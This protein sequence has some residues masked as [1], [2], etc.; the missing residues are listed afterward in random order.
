MIV[1]IAMTLAGGAGALARYLVSRV[2]TAPFGT[3]IV[4]VTGAFALGLL[5]GNFVLG[6]GF[7]GAYSTFSTWMLETHDLAQ[8]RRAAALANVLGSLAIGLA[9]AR[10]GIGLRERG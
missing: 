3:L 10:V 7:V 2:T 5:G 6:T 1:W 9:A 4:N 8:E